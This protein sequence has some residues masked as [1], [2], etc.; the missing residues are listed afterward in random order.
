MAIEFPWM[1]HTVV[2][3][4]KRDSIRGGPANDGKA[5]SL[6]PGATF[7]AFVEAKSARWAADTYGVETERRPYLVI[8]TVGTMRA[9]Q[10]GDELTFNGRVLDIA[11]APTIH[12]YGDGYSHGECMAMGEKT[13]GRDL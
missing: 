11:F 4:P 1:P 13:G 10:M 6:T 2:W 9:L 8:G 5:D 3:Q 7:P 12:D